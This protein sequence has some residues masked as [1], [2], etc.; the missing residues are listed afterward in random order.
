M[1][2]G[3]I[4][5]DLDGTLADTLSDI[6]ASMNRVLKAHNFPQHPRNDYKT[7]IGRGLDN[8]VLQALPNSARQPAMVAK[9]LAEM[10]EDYRE[11]C[12]EE[13]CLYE[14]IQSMLQNLASLGM[15]MGIFSNKAEPLTYK[16]VARLMPEVRFVK[17][18]GARPDTPKKPDP[19]G[20]HFILSH[21]NLQAREVVYLGDSDVDMAMAV[22]AGMYAVGVLWGFRSKEELLANGARHIL[23]HPSELF[24]LLGK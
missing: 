18:V 3:G 9:C 10:M 17:V 4:I 11:N 21:M 24:G 7:L 20:A 14:G 1:T 19:A 22:N 23:Q 13:T 2:F 15:K 12:L 8:L 16:I 5:F 6:A